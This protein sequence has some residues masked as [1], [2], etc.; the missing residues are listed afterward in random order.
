MEGE[1]K[2]ATARFRVRDARV[3]RLLWRNRKELTEAVGRIGLALNMDVAVQAAGE[4][5]PGWGPAAPGD[6]TPPAPG[7]DLKV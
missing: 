4:S 7:V 6:R 5:M 3:R 1:K 2:T